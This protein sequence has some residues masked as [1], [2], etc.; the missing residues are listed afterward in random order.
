MTS[1]QRFQKF[2]LDFGYFCIIDYSWTLMTIS[3][4]LQLPVASKKLAVDHRWSFQWKAYVLNG[5]GTF[6]SHFPTEFLAF[7]CFCCC[8]HSQWSVD[9][10]YWWNINGK[11]PF[12]L[13][14]IAYL[15]ASVERYWILWRWYCEFSHK[16]RGSNVFGH[17]WWFFVVIL[18]KKIKLLLKKNWNYKS[19]YW[20]HYFLMP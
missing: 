2:F 14:N 4:Y 3:K 5:S 9:M 10:V 16:F 12:C 13:I 11:Q 19:F 8:F 1:M 7:A 18:L 20:K 6:F 17:I 15:L